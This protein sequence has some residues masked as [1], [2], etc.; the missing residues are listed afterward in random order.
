MSWELPSF[1][2][3]KAM[4]NVEINGV[5]VPFKEV[6]TRLSKHCRPLFF[7][8]QN[9][10]YDLAYSG[11]SLLFRVG[12]HNFQLST[13]HQFRMEGQPDFSQ[14]DS[15]L[16]VEEDGRHIA[17]TPNGASRVVL[18]PKADDFLPEDIALQEYDETRNGRDLNPSFLKMPF[19]DMKT[20]EDVDPKSILL[21]FSIG[22]P[23]SAQGYD[24]TFNDD[25]EVTDVNVVSRFLPIY[26]DPESIGPS[27]E[28]SR[29]QISV[30]DSYRN[31]IG[32]AN[33]WSGAPIFFIWRSA[34]D[35]AHLGFGGMI[36]HGKDEGRFLIFRG[37]DIQEVV[38]KVLRTEP[39]E[40]HPKAIDSP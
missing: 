21:V 15:C 20:F 12:S 33:G 36:T 37:K 23:S 39:N 28:V 32:Q 14:V 26:F 1:A 16:L 40:I 7:Y 19:L 30:L 6:P 35:V 4:L 25:Y 10:S 34:G 11:S 9:S 27:Y 13:K 18:D 5:L 31:V 24:M 17:L 38:S 2:V 29:D 22:Y 8:R 3:A